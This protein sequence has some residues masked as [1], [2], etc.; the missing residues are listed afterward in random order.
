MDACLNEQKRFNAKLVGF[1]FAN[2]KDYPLLH[3]SHILQHAVCRA[4]EV[5]VPGIADYLEARVKES[6]QL[7]AEVLKTTD[8]R[9]DR[10]L[11]ARGHEYALQEFPIWADKAVVAEELFDAKGFPRRLRLCFFDIPNCADTSDACDHFFNALSDSDNLDIFNTTIVNI[12]VNKAWRE[13]RAFFVWFQVLPQL[14]LLLTYLFWLH[15]VAADTDA[16]SLFKTEA[17]QEK[18]GTWVCYGVLFI[19]T[20]ILSQELYQLRRDCRRYFGSIWNFLDLLPLGFAAFGPILMLSGYQ[21]RRAAAGVGER[22]L[23][24]ISGEPPSVD[25][26][27]PPA[28]DLPPTEELNQEEVLDLGEPELG[29]ETTALRLALTISQVVASILL[30]V[31][32]LYYL[33]TQQEFGYLI[34][35]IIEVAKD[36]VSFLIMMAV[37]ILAFSEAT[38]SLSNNRVPVERAFESY[39]QA[40]WFS[41]YNAMGNFIMDGFEEDTIGWALFFAC[42]LFNMIVMLNLLIAIISETYN[43]VN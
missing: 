1:L 29:E 20:I 30:W 7:A 33:R 32:L 37:A 35:M 42:T 36:M 19:C 27:S 8:L 22:L 13:L 6:P 43:R 5:D 18:I 24:E 17:Q 23:S 16:Q 15:Y 11:M 3:S 38:Y 10:K 14:L 41:F 9:S 28:E 40:L 34:R 4:I 26:G 2:T 39:F 25:A 12:L 21:I 31:K